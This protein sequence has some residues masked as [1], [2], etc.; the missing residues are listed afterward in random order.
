MGVGFA[1]NAAVLPVVAANG[2]DGINAR[3]YS[4]TASNWS[5]TATGTLLWEA[6]ID[7][8]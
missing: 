2:G 8:F 7:D 4:S 3:L 1:G 5:A 6:M